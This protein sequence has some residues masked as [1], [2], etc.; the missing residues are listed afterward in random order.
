MY[1]NNARFES[2]GW[3]D[4]PKNRQ[5]WAQLQRNDAFLQE[6]ALQGDLRCHYCH[7]Y[8]K[9][10]HWSLNYNGVDLATADHVI[11]LSR[12]GY[13]GHSNMVVACRPCNLAKGSY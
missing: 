5:R 11:P 8:V 9:I 7:K 10:V 12:G 6:K 13:D 2:S 3:K 1:S 4:T